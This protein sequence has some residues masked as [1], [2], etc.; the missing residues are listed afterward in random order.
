MIAE[1]LSLLIDYGVYLLPGLSLCALW[2][3]LTPK[4]QPGLRIALRYEQP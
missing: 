2:F 4:T 3:W 1:G